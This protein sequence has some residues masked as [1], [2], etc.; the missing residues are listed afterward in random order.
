LS[1]RL[2]VL[3]LVAILSGSLF[4]QAPPQNSDQQRADNVQPEKTSHPKQL[5]ARD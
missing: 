2:C 4:A 1:G 3:G 5:A